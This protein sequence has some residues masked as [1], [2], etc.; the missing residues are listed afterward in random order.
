MMYHFKSLTI[1]KKKKKRLCNAKKKRNIKMAILQLP[2]GKKKNYPNAVQ[3]SS[4][5]GERKVRWQ[6]R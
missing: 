6:H 2:K 1:W 4:W 5:L 3:V